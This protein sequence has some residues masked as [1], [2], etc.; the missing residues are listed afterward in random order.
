MTMRGPGSAHPRWEPWG[1][2]S[3]LLGTQADAEVAVVGAAA[4]AAGFDER[5]GNTM[6][7]VDATATAVSTATTHSHRRH[8]KPLEG[9]LPL[10][11]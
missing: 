8:R 6:A 10:L 2:R 3:P 4:R 7:R 11:K 5:I 9:G 1:P